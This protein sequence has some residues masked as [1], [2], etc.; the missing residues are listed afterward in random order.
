MRR[1]YDLAV[2]VI[3]GVI[4]ADFISG[5]Y[6]KGTGNLAPYGGGSGVILS[7]L[8]NIWGTT[9]NA[10][11]GQVTPDQPAGPNPP[12]SQKKPVPKPAPKPAPTKPPGNVT[13]CCL[14]FFGKCLF[15]SPVC[16]WGT[17]QA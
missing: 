11:L 4:L 1:V 12:A 6:T 17:G 2:V 9:V 10:M 5:F 16:V 14:T 13:Q 8:G 15:H 7:G 3:V